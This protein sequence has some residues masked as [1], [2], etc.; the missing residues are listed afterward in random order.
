MGNGQIT[1]RRMSGGPITFDDGFATR[2]RGEYLEM[3]GLRLT[4]KQ[5]CRLWQLDPTTC[6]TV[7]ER[8]IA[9]GFLRRKENGT[10]IAVA[11][12]G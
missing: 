8:L 2:I 4:F 7:L 10:F 5:A 12:S 11:A 6:E 3:P 9:E 1:E